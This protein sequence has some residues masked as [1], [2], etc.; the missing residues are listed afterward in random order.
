EGIEP[1]I[2]KIH[3][4]GVRVVASLIIH[5][6]VVQA[7]FIFG[8]LH[9]SSTS[10]R[11]HGAAIAAP[12]QQAVAIAVPPWLAV[13]PISQPPIMPLLKPWVGPLQHFSVLEP[14][15]NFPNAVRAHW[16]LG[17][18]WSD[19]RTCRDVGYEARFSLSQQNRLDSCTSCCF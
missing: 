7:G 18:V 10:N 3:R 5:G 11:V 8:C 14:L 12:F 6:A 17:T 1:D 15:V 4:M 9:E 2:L 16:R 19:T 13:T